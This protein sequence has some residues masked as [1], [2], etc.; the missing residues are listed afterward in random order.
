MHPLMPTSKAGLPLLARVRAISLALPDASED[1]NHGRPCFTVA[2]KTFAMFLDN[3]HGDG[4]IAIWCKAAPGDQGD[5][6]ESDPKRFFVPPYVG[7][8]GWIGVRLDA[9][10]PDWKLVAS[11]IGDSYRLVAPKRSPRRKDAKSR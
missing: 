2:K 3:H 8:R 9:P 4:R 6:V 5:M 1:I 10:K 11:I 7:P